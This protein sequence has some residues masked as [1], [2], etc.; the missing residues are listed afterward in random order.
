MFSCKKNTLP[1]EPVITLTFP[2]D[3][4]VINAGDTVLIKGII[5]DNKNLHEV[6][7]NL[8]DSAN[9]FVFFSDNPYTHGAKSYYYSYVWITSSANAYKFVIEAH[10]HD[11][12]TSKKEFPLVVH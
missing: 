12:H 3:T 7:F 6:F 1:S 9:S 11:N 8:T 4:A 10:D 5:S 2:S